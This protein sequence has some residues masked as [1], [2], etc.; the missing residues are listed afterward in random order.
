LLNTGVIVVGLKIQSTGALDGRSKVVFR[1][2]TSLVVFFDKYGNERQ[3]C[4]ST[5]HTFVRDELTVRRS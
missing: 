3:G 2:I 4:Q 5:H 1:Y